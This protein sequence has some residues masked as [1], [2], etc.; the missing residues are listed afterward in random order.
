MLASLSDMAHMDR[1]IALLA[2][3]RVVAV[4]RVVPTL[5]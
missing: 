1:H 2:E 5:V 3:S 4:K